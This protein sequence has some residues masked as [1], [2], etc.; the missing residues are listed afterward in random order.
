MERQGKARQ[1]SQNQTQIERAP[2]VRKQRIR[3]ETVILEPPGYSDTGP[4]H[5]LEYLKNG[6]LDKQT[7]T[8]IKARSQ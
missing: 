5:R 1:T 6:V 3:V 7:L 4:K 2:Q 8:L